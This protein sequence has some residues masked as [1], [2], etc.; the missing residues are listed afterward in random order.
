[1]SHQKIDKSLINQREVARRLGISPSYVNMIVNGI[2]T[3]AK[4]QEKAK[5][6]ETLLKTSLKA[7]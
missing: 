7:A 5:E 6:I 1:M 2:R 4:A 3:G